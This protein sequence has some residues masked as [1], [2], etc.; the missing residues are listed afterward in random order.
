V[1]LEFPGFEPAKE[2]EK[3]S[4]M[5]KSQGYN[6]GDPEQL[7]GLEMDSEDEDGSGSE[8]TTFG[9]HHSRHSSAACSEYDPYPLSTRVRRVVPSALKVINFVKDGLHDELQNLS[10]SEIDTLLGRLRNR[11]RKI[12]R[13][14][15]S[16]IRSSRY[17]GWGTSRTEYD[18]YVV[19]ENA[20]L[21]AYVG[22]VD[23]IMLPIRERC[24]S[25]QSLLSENSDYN[26]SEYD[27]DRDELTRNDMEYLRFQ[28]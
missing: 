7:D 15:A 23:G 21:N 19:L 9:R 5:D 27:S 17:P 4:K 14:G 25:S 20:Q 2:G 22:L 11:R 13:L 24:N 28:S 18:E 10:S 16:A 3:K 1:T 6:S 12:I 26:W 8:S